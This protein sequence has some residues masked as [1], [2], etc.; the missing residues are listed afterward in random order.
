MEYPLKFWDYLDQDDQKH[1]EKNDGISAVEPECLSERASLAG[2]AADQSAE[3]MREAAH[4]LTGAD[5]AHDV[6]GNFRDSVE[7]G[8]VERL[9]AVEAIVKGHQAHAEH[10]GFAV[11]GGENHSGHR[12]IQLA[13]LLEIAE[14]Q[15]H[16]AATNDSAGGGD[17]DEHD[18]NER[19]GVDEHRAGGG[20]NK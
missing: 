17:G 3:D 10:S 18:D 19:E 14:D 2:A 5:S 9:A 16:S 12:E 20:L 8:L 11:G 6:A 4:A 13:R 7:E 1:G 15:E